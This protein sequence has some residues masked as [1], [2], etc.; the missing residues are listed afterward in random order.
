MIP[1]PALSPS[2]PFPGL[3]PFEYEE[4]A[5]FFGREGQSVEILRRL[6]KKKFIG[7]I[8]VSGSG[9]S[10]LIRAGLLPF[11]D[12][13][14]M[15][16]AGSHWR[17]AILRPGNCPIK[18]LAA[19]LAKPGA[20]REKSRPQTDPADLLFLEA[21]LRAS[22]LGLVEAVRQA[23]LAVH[24]NVLVVVDQMEEL[25]RF[26]RTDEN[27]QQESEAAAFV[28]LLLEATRQNQLPI[29]VVI[30]MRSDFIGDCARFRDLP[31]TINEGLYLIPRMTRDQRK[32]AITG[33]LRTR[34]TEISP[35][36]L[37]RLLNDVG[38]SPDQLPILQHALMRTFEFWVTDHQPGEPLDLRH[39]QKIGTM[40]GALSQHAEE[41]F[42]NLPDARHQDI[43][44]QI[45]QLLTEKGPDNREIRR[46]TTVGEIMAVTGATLP[47]VLA[48]IDCFRRAGR[49]FLTSP[50]KE[51]FDESS[52]IDISHESLIRGWKRL[53]EWLEEEA[54]AAS[55]FR[56]LAQTA[57][58]HE[59][60]EAG[61]YRDPDLQ[62]ALNEHFTEPWAKRYYPGFV[63]AMQFLQ[64]SRAARDAESAQKERLQREALHRAWMFSGVVTFLL[65]IA[66]VL[67]LN[68]HR[69]KQIAVRQQ[70]IADKTAA[71]LR[72]SEGNLR[73]SEGKLKVS[74]ANLKA[75][76]EQL[77]SEKDQKEKANKALTVALQGLNETN[78]K[79]QESYDVLVGSR[80]Q[81][82]D[83]QGTI[84]N[85]AESLLDESNPQLAIYAQRRKALA[86]T[87]EG[88]HQAAIQTLTA[89]LETDPNDLPALSSRGYEYL[90][91][92]QPEAS[93]SDSQK[94]LETNP[95]SEIALLN[96]AIGEAILGHY[97]EAEYA[98]ENA[99]NVYNPSESGM[100]ESDV[101]PDIQVVAHR[102]L[103]VEENWQFLLGLKYERAVLDAAQGNR[104]FPE[105]LRD[106]DKAAR[107]YPESGRMDAP[108]LALNWAWLQYR[109]RPADYG[110]LAASGALWD[111]VASTSPQFKGCARKQY[112]KFRS[113]YDKGH[114]NSHRYDWL[115]A[116]VA[117]E[118]AQAGTGDSCSL[119]EVSQDPRELALEA[120]ELQSRIS[121]SNKLQL[122]IVEKKL[123]QA[124]QI[125][126]AK[127]GPYHDFLIDLFMRRAEVRYQAKD[128]VGVRED[129][130][131]VLRLNGGV[132]RAYYYLAQ[133]S[134]DPAEVRRNYEAALRYDPI[135][136]DTLEDFADFLTAK[137]DQP[138]QDQDQDQAEALRLIQRATR[139][140]PYWS[141]LYQREAK[142]Q[143]LL[144]DYD[145]ALG[146]IETAIS[147]APDS[148]DYYLLRADIEKNLKQ[149]DDVIALHLAAGYRTMGDAYRYRGKNGQALVDYLKS[150]ATICDL[151]SGENNADTNDGLTISMRSLSDFLT[152]RYS[153][154]YA[155]Q[156]WDNMAKGSV[157][158]TYSARAQREA[159]RLRAYQVGR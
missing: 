39:Y 149:S 12:G 101:L 28:K 76:L 127:P 137:K 61:L 34:N 135:D 79:L 113:E 112:I 71:D 23:H 98:L 83:D 96:L 129:A 64:D 20:L 109:D 54:Q 130:L 66:V 18:N 41:A 87:L 4:Y 85:L 44:R 43:A 29:Y 119:T 5:L 99:I 153:R 58:L 108:L 45:F 120:Q 24:E 51:P 84:S 75:D 33:P 35:R 150:I 59:R 86:L 91:V 19:E 49:S 81:L 36:L 110:L 37:N 6:R 118:L 157:M 46:P 17:K 52:V 21:T 65:I 128:N 103:M 32:E 156:F 74:E 102:K 148:E 82:I 22:G 80:Q 126:S 136:A 132:A 111:R 155:S 131:S 142:L 77:Q 92:G 151:P 124:I 140:R 47:Q 8:G 70:Q 94:Y 143:N 90:L 26:A 69:Q 60:N 1:D 154:K 15:V 63:Q 55:I 159:D 30:T 3:R 145:S 27:A 7:V 62:I 67:G 158:K 11:L 42:N 144:G 89:V 104:R 152:E 10:S 9:K 97:Q 68:A 50:S 105:S 14:M 125:A 133:V 115:N 53:N 114:K 121:G 147:R 40:A 138:S 2:N 146:S 117:S 116:W 88:N 122:K 57:A 73:V 38:D 95:R 123:T 16:E 56:R 31:E 100:Y 106:A 134:T 139:V 48:T 72:V 13:A 25:F 141:G 78:K 107:E 93:V